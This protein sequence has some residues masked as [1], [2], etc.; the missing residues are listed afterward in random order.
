MFKLIERPMTDQS[1]PAEDGRNS[2]TL[3]LAEYGWSAHFQAQLDVSDVKT[4][5]PVRVMA[6]HRNGIDV[7]GPDYQ[8]RIAPI[9]SAVENAGPA[10]ATV[11]DWLLIDRASRAAQRVLERK[12]LFRRKAAGPTVRVQLIAANVDTLFIVSSCNQD[13][14]PARIERYLAIARTA[15]VTPVIILTK[16]D[17][18]SDVEALVAQAA[19]LAHGLLIEALDARSPDIA[20]RLSMWCAPG[21]TV[22]LM[23][24]SGVGKSTLL[25]TLSGDVVQATAEIRAGDDKGK[26]TTTRRSL[27]RLAGGAWL[28]DTPGMRELQLTNVEEGLNSVF[29]D[30]AELAAQC[31]FSDCLHDTEPGCAV[32]AALHDGRLDEA[33]LKRYR[34]L[35]REEARN[36]ETLAEAHARIRSFSRQVRSSMK[37]KRDRGSS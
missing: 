5:L 34:K 2:K 1:K 7:A 36:T 37:A 9:A 27:H 15:A 12:S 4:M 3:T 35:L 17:L 20:R 8:G 14:N 31:R 25:N 6:V 13:F 32:R 26:H 21:Q 30:V 29:A 24:S 10:G 33:R 18:A 11:G 23:G 16:A 22:A 28:I 19:R